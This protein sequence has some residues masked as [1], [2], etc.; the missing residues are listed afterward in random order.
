MIWPSKQNTSGKISQT[1]FTW[2]TGKKPQEPVGAPKRWYAFLQDCTLRY[3]WIKSSPQGG[4]RLSLIN[5]KLSSKAVNSNTD[6][7]YSQLNIRIK[8]NANLTEALFFTVTLKAV[9]LVTQ[10]N[11]TDLAWKI[12]K[13]Q[14]VIVSNK[15]AAE[16]SCL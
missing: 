2:Q 13:G 16:K 10:N 14:K 3:A 6:K 15:A 12:L 8:S 4:S 1:N 9:L 7:I 5:L 11:E